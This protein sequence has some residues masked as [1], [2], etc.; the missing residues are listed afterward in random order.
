MTTRTP[1]AARFIDTHA[2]LESEQ[3]DGRQNLVIQTALDA[4][5]Q[6]IIA[7]TAEQIDNC[8]C[9][10]ANTLGVLV[11]LNAI[12]GPLYGSQ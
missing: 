3:F 9:S 8:R 2:H 10:T 1:T 4:G 11:R 6:K 7:I 12:L 5:V